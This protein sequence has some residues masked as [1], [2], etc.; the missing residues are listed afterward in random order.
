MGGLLAAVGCAWNF[1]SK[2]GDFLR[3]L[4]AARDP[5][6]RF[7]WS[8]FKSWGLCTISASRARISAEIRAVEVQKLRTFWIVRVEALSQGQVCLTCLRLASGQRPVS[9]V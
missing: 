7:A 1:G 2:T 4:Q 6:R 3:F 9:R 5:L 8:R